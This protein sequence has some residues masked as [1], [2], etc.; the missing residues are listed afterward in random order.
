MYVPVSRAK[1]MAVGICH[2]D[3]VAP[4]N[5][6]KLALT[7]P[8]SGGCLVGIFC[9]RAQATVFFKCFLMYVCNF[10]REIS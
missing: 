1:N 2:A 3:H 9:S 5:P 7:L 6:Q 4:S 10:I 8:T